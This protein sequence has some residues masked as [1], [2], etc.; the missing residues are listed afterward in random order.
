M[1]AVLID[2]E[3]GKAL[4]SATV[5]GTDV[6]RDL[7]LLAVK[8]PLEGYAFVRSPEPPRLGDDVAALG[9]PLGLPLTITRGT[10]SGMGRVVEIDGIK[11]RSL[12]RPAAQAAASHDLVHIAREQLVD[13]TTRQQLSVEGVSRITHRDGSHLGHGR[14]LRGSRDMARPATSAQVAPM[15]V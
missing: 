15:S 10:V 5:V 4:G 8:Q 14:I 3:A 2:D 13:L 1:L 6:D 9:F 11:R 12:V 7:A